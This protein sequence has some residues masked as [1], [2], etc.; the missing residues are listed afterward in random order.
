MNA[1]TSTL[2]FHHDWGD[3]NGA[4]SKYL[5]GGGKK[6]RLERAIAARE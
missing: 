2:T 5:H 1:F 3:P 4:K 6:G